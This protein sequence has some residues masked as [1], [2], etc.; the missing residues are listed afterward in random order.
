MTASLLAF[1]VMSTAYRFEP[2]VEHEYMLK[3]TF[4]GFIPILGGV[5]GT[6]GVEIGFT[7]MGGPMKEGHQTAASELTSF[8]LKFGGEPL[9]LGLDAAQEFFPKTTVQLSPLGK[10]LKTDAPDKDLPVKLPGLDAQKFPDFTY[11]PILLPEEGLVTGGKWSFERIFGGSPLKYDC[12]V[13]SLAGD[14]AKINVKVEQKYEVF[15]DD[16]LQVVKEEADAAV[17]AKTVMSGSGQVQF[18]TKRGLVVKSLIKAAA[19]TEVTDLATKEV[20][21]RS[22]NTE[23]RSDLL[24]IDPE[25]Y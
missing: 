11:L 22:L 5:E 17:L 16:A 19:E 15:E 7:V 4:E 20:T 18:D 14:L 6:A 12:T 25:V 23:Y 21:T 3:T 8:V 13:E 10:V 2:G 1:A 24:P 9:P